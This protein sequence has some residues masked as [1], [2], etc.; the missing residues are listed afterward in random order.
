MAAVAVAVGVV[1]ALDGGVVVHR[2]VAALLGERIADVAGN[3]AAGAVIAALLD[4]AGE[5]FDGRSPGSYSTVAVCATG[6]A[7][8]ARRRDGASTRSTTAFSEA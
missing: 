6:F 2:R 1:G 3:R 7:S 4:P 8:T 5:R